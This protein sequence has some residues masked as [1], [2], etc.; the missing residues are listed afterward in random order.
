MLL[1]PLGATAACVALA[2]APSRTC[3]ITA[4]DSPQPLPADA[5][6]PA[7]LSLEQVAVG[8]VVFVLLHTMG[9][10]AAQLSGVAT[11][12]AAVPVRL[13]ATAGF[14]AVQTAVGLPPSQWLLAPPARPARWRWLETPY[15]PAVGTLALCV[16]AALPAAVLSATGDSAALAAYLPTPRP[17]DLP[18]LLDTLAAAPLTEELFFRAWLLN[19]LSSLEVPD[20][21]ALGVSVLL[22]VLWHLGVDGGAASHAATGLWF[23]LLYQRGGGLRVSAGTHALWNGCVAALRALR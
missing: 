7:K 8:G 23:G 10:T 14:V 9:L 18:R 6:S 22:F 3:S 1:H 20:G 12:G 21:A 4:C 19:A 15:A 16:A 13:A 5:P 2:C 17:L 11:E